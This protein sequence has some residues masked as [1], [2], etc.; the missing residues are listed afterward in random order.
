[1]SMSMEKLNIKLNINE[2]KN[3]DNDIES[4]YKIEVSWKDLF[5]SYEL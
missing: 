3:E 5:N 1:M 2:V 4:E